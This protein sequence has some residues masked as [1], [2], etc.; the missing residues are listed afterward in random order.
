MRML[1]TGS[2]GLL[3]GDVAMELSSRGHGVLGTGPRGPERTDFDPLNA[4]GASKLEGERAVTGT[5]DEYFIVRTQWLYGPRNGGFAGAVLR[6]GMS[7][8]SVRGSP[9]FHG[10]IRAVGGRQTA[11]RQTQRA[12][13]G[14][15]RIHA[16]SGLE[17]RGGKVRRPDR[18]ERGLGRMGKVRIVDEP[19]EGLLVLESAV[20][21]DSRGSFEETWNEADMA[22]IGVRARFVQDN[23][24]VSRRGVL[25]GMHFQKEHP[26]AKLVRAA[27]GRVFDAVIDMRPGSATFGKWFGT[28]LPAGVG[29]SL[30]IPEGFAHGFYVLSDMAIFCYKVTDFWHP[31]DEGGVAWDDPAV[32]IGWP[33]RRG[34]DPVLSEKDRLYEPFGITAGRLRDGR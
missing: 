10:G 7:R 34:E 4:Y 31:G 24:S 19:M 3:G 29:R 14:G 2:N 28:E 30:Y 20:A 15:A 12:I 11:G 33:I 22:E 27:Y 25:R 13:P 16:A 21:A 5:L 9:G 18:G 23:Q 1:V 17:G 6:A 26:Q 32:G 8:A